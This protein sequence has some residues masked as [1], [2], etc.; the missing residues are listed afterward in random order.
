MYNIIIKY[1][2][3]FYGNTNLFAYIKLL[4]SGI[5]ELDLES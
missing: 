3:S 1:L 2:G 5:V 4:L